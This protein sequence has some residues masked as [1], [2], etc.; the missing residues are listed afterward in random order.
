MDIKKA[1][2]QKKGNEVVKKL[3]T[4]Q[5]EAYYCNSTNDAVRKVLELIPNDHVVSWGGS[6]TIQDIGLLDA[7]RKGGYRCID[8]DTTRDQEERFE[9]MRQA[10]LADTFLMSSN[11]ITEDGQLFNIDGNGNRVAALCYGPKSVIVIAGMNKVV[12]SLQDAISRG[13]TY[14][15]PM[16]MQRFEEQKLP[17]MITGECLDCIC[18]DCGC[19]SM[20]VT[21]MSKPAKRIK[22]IL[23]GEDLGI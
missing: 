1:L 22:V 13:R 2:Y 12:K 17:C 10:L 23:I 11:A 16:N 20:V 15:A 8:R 6:K 21:R 19:I 9:L 14:A 18:P 5:F 4:R 3:R 7:V